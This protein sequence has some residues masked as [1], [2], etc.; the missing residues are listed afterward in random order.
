MTIWQRLWI[1]DINR[2]AYTACIECVD[3]C[4]CVHDR[5]ARGVDEQSALLHQSKLLATN[6]MMRLSRRRQNQDYDL[7]LWQ[8]TVERADGMNGRFA[9]HAA[10]HALQLDVKGR[11]HSLYLLADGSITYQQHSLAGEFFE[12][13]WRIERARVASDAF[14]VR[15][16]F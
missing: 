3:Q 16:R 8:E 10:G 6:H 13:Y 5:S 7:R 4:A 14:I 1:G 12:H 9:A 11:E 15:P 2:G